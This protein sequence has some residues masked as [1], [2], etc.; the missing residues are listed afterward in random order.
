MRKTLVSLVLALVMLAGLAL[1]AL[2]A[3]APTV[4]RIA[5]E[6]E[7]AHLDTQVITNDCVSMISQHIFETLYTYDENYNV[8]P[9]L[10]EGDE[11]SEDG[12]IV[13]IT[14]RQGVKF[15]NG[16]EMTAEDV[17]ASLSRWFQYGSR[18]SQ[19]AGYL[20]KLEVKD[21]YTITMTFNAPY[22]AWKNLFAFI[23]GGPAI[24][25]SEVLEGRDKT[26]LTEDL[27]IGTGPYKFVAHEAAR[28]FLLEKFADYTPRT[29]APSGLSGARVANFDQ[30]MFIPVTNA[31][32]RINGLL[33]GDYDYIRIAT[34]DMYD[35]LSANDSLVVTVN[36][37]S[38]MPLMFF[39]SRDRVFANNDKMRQAVL[40]ALDMEEIMAI[41]IGPDDLWELNGSI[42]PSWNQFYSERG[43]E[44]YNK[45]DPELARQMAKEAG[46]NGEEIVILIN[47]SHQ[48]HI[49]CCTVIEQQLEK[50]GFN[51]TCERLDAAAQQAKRADASQYDIH[52]THHI[53]SPEPVIYNWMNSGYAGWWDTPEK[54][55]L[56]AEYVGATTD[57]AKIEAWAKIQ[58]LTYQQIPVIK[59]GDTYE[60]DVYAK[61]LQGF[62][63]N[64][65]IWP[66]FWGISK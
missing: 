21:A 13:T 17:Y 51:V 56:V 61:G 32:T 19:I 12:K 66:H 8:L 15:H 28:Y 53:F 46:Y 50:A 4:L 36:K 20:D 59:M 3:D 39:N 18:A 2:A 54:N 52:F 33:A 27:Y 30:L 43:L 62:E 37:G 34:G 42:N 57:E 65:P 31:S 49:D 38:K 25:P 5:A 14:L 9:M 63:V 60:Y 35:I 58:E 23:N 6:N 40:A 24:Y 55:A 26:A 44:L 22:S 11:T 47:N 1:P 48:M 29:E 45:A 7:P 41:A 16:K 64:A 10:A